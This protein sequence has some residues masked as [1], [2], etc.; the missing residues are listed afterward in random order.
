MPQDLSAVKSDFATQAG[1]YAERLLDL[2]RDGEELEAFWFDRAFGVGSAN[3]IQQGHLV[4]ENAHLTPAI[5]ADVVNAIGTLKT[6]LTSGIRGNLR[7]A[8]RSVL[9]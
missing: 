4:G 7:R 8:S 9:A 5:L 1:A 6:A 2:V 3:E